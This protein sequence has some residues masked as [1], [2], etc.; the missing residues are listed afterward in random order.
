MEYKTTRRPTKGN[1]QDDHHDRTYRFRA[2]GV[3]RRAVRRYGH[4]RRR[5]V[6][7]HGE[8]R[9]VKVRQRTRRPTRERTDGRAARLVFGE[10]AARRETKR[11]ALLLDTMGNNKTISPKS[12][13]TTG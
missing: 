12:T 2:A 4:G 9:F 7:R 5:L 8:V 13:L 11:A 6:P 3:R 10:R 1:R